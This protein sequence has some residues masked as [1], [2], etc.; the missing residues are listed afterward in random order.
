MGSEI[1]ERRSLRLG[2]LGCADIAWRRTLPAVEATP[3][4]ELVAVASREP[5]KAEKFAQ[6]FGA[7]PVHGYGALLERDDVD[8]VY[9]PLPV[10]L[11][12]RWI[13]RVLTSGRHVLAEKPLTTGHAQARELTAEA[14]RRGLVVMENFTFPFHR[15]HTRVRELVEEG[16]A[17]RIRAFMSEFGV[18][19]RA[20]D[21]IRLDPELGGS[22]LLD[23]GV[24]PLRI[25][26]FLFGTGLEVEGAVL[27]TDPKTGVDVGGGVLLRGPGG[28]VA[29]LGFGFGVHYRNTYTLWGEEGVL[30]LDR[31]FTPPEDFRPVIGLDTATGTESFELEPDHQFRN[32]LS[33]FAES[34]RERRA[35]HTRVLALA[36]LVDRVREMAR[37][38]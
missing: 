3:G 34:V 27:T 22:A 31:A 19:A 30:R 5:A 36:E 18:P 26:Q 28:E 25:A 37:P 4:V 23:V 17:G 35:D 13:M 20:E 11:R 10:A 24:Y 16:R 33:A 14:E 32:T 15:Q 6:R 38:L 2:V 9:V 29:Q 7:A 8:A 21:D 12:H 1:D